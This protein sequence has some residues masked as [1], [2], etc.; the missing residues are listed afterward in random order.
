MPSGGG[1]RKLFSEIVKN[2]DDNKRYRITLKP[3]E[4]TITLEQIK[5]QLKKSINPTDIKVGIKAVKTIRDRGLII[6]TGSEEERNI[7]S[8]EISNKLG[9]RLDII[10]HKL[11]KPRLIIYSVPEEITTE[12]VG[13]IIRAQNPEV[14]NADE[15]IETKYRFKNKR[16]R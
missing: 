10:Q 4:E 8:M 9:E 11:R 15:N 3:K 2:Q 5:L 16:S 1:R 14:L 6:E 7:L 13:A 12:N